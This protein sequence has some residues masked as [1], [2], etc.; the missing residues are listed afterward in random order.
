MGRFVKP[1][2]SNLCRLDVESCHT[3]EHTV[4]EL[5]PM[6]FQAWRIRS[7]CAIM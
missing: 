7:E 1:C 2:W 5:T 6:C 4:R 3:I